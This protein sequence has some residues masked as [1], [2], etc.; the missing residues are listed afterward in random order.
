MKSIVFTVLLSAS[1]MH[2]TVS[3]QPAPDTPAAA[4]AEVQLVGTLEQRLA[5]GGETTGWLLR[6]GGGK[7]RVQVLLPPA[8]FA[9]IKDGMAVAVTGV[10]GTKHYPERGDVAVFTVKKITQVVH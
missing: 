7:E 10:Y 6:H 1:C 8:A 9:W 2:S 3:G 4:A 5:I